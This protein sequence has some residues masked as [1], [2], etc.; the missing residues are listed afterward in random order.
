MPKSTHESWWITAPEPV[1]GT[2]SILDYQ[3]RSGKTE[4]TLLLN[5]RR[6]ASAVYA[7]VMCLSVCMSVTS[8]HCTKMAKRRITQTTSYDSPVTLVFCR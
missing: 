5:V 2:G 3:L 4:H 6:Y 1:Q 7:V 8:R